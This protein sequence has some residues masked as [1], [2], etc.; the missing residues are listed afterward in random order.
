MNRDDLLTAEQAQAQL[1]VSRATLWNL[2][3]R[4]QIPRYQ[5]PASGRRV[6]FKREDIQRLQEPVRMEA[7]PGKAA[8]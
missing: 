3:K 1:G 7:Q 2:L 5:I 4:H 6:F 8:A